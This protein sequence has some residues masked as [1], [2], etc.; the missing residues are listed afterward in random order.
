MESK[1]NKIILIVIACGIWAIVLQNM[2]IIPTAQNVEVVN[3]VDVGGTV[4]VGNT[5]NVNGYVDVGEVDVNI[6]KVNG[7]NTFYNRGGNDKRYN[8]IPVYIGDN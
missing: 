4:D 7:Y 3:S 8:R 2:G 5:V 1:N 6:S